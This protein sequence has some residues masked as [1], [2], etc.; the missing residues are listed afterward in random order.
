MN[1]K[2]LTGTEGSISSKSLTSLELTL[3]A[4]KRLDKIPQVYDY[5]STNML[6]LMTLSVEHL[7]TTSHIKLPL[8]TQLQYTRDFMSTLK[9]SIK[10]SGNW[11]AFYFTSRKASWYLPTE[12]TIYLNDVLKELPKKKNPTKITQNEQQ[13]L[14]S[15]PVTYT[16]AVRQSTVKQET[17]MAKMGTLPH[18]LSTQNTHEVATNTVP[19]NNENDKR[20]ANCEHLTDAY[21]SQ[22]DEE[23]SDGRCNLKET[24]EFSEESDV[25]EEN[26]GLVDIDN[27]SLFLVGRASRFRKTKKINNRF[28]ELIR[29][30][31]HKIFFA[32]KEN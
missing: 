31:Y 10:K 21:I 17:T 7:H 26:T 9:K 32:E 24:D 2:V 29:F 25:E 18:Y 19:Y 5:K 6:S 14:H 12:N 3:W 27:T 30:L 15:W 22:N 23:S 20:A 1:L 11:S 8:M 16:R 4:P 28:L 13:A